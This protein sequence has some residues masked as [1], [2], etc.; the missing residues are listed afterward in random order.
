MAGRRQLASLRGAFR[1]LTDRLSGRVF[2]I[3]A[4]HASAPSSQVLYRLQDVP[5]GGVIGVDL[6]RQP[7]VPLVLCRQGGSMQAWLNT[8][9][10]DGRRM[11]RAP[12]L[13]NVKDGTLR[14]PVRGARFALDDGGI[15]TSGPCRGKSLTFVAVRVQGGLVTIQ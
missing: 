4:E 7:G 8:C 13:F 10:Q 14:C 6:P 15:C 11:N 3:Q 12:G 2:G 9:P 1:R 5:D